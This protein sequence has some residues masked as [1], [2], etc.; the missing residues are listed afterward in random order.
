MHDEEAAPG[1][2][3]GTARQERRGS[4]WAWLCVLVPLAV[5]VLLCLC[6][7]PILRDSWGHY[8]WFRAGGVVDKPAVIDNSWAAYQVGNP[9]LGQ[10]FTFLLFSSELLHVGATAAMVLAYL[11]LLTALA[12]GRWP[13]WRR[14]DD[15]WSFLAVVAMTLVAVPQ[16]GPMLFYRAFVG[17]YVYGFLLH[18]VLYLP[19][20]GFFVTPGTR[21]RWWAPALLVWGVLA[22]L[23]NEHTGPASIA[24]LFV[25][26]VWLRRRGDR[27]AAWMFAGL[28][29]LVV[30]YLLLFFAPG[31]SLRYSGL[32]AQQGL[33]E[34]VLSRPWHESLL[35]PLPLLIAV[36]SATPWWLLAEKARR[37]LPAR[38]PR[39]ELLVALALLGAAALMVL[40]LYASPK[41]GKR[42]FFA[43]SSLFVVAVAMWLRPALAWPAARRTLVALSAAAA[44][45]AGARLLGTYRVLHR[46]FTARMALL[47]GGAGKDVVVPRYTEPQSRWFFGDDLRAGPLR[48]RL[49]NE[50][51]L[52]SLRLAPAKAGDA[53][54]DKR[55]DPVDSLTPSD[56]DRRD[57][58]PP[59]VSSAA[60]APSAS[61][62]DTQRNVSRSIFK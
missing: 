54:P 20:R 5:V 35:L 44:L 6:W 45:Y 3:E 56:A 9:R 34:R 2:A 62:G 18:V 49:V 47:D 57:A 19:Y 38:L 15:A 55:V 32:G 40:A 7:E 8:L 25:T 17:N 10:F 36:A 39:R 51:A 4:A 31:Q 11:W 43:P 27:L 41:H 53:N 16:I 42:L 1:C 50:L 28:G 22:G 59:S 48:E 13:S 24:L 60:S 26:L 61:A 14:R 23:T 52:G 37:R 21:P 30:G 29:G 33:L 12:L 46:E 58:S